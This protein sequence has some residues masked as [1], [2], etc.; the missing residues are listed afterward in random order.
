MNPTAGE[1]D[2]IVLWHGTSESVEKIRAEGLRPER[3]E[4]VFLTD[5]PDLA[6]DYAVTDQARTGSDRIT[7]VEVR[8]SD[9]D[10]SRLLG[11]IDHTLAEDWRDSLAETD[12]CMYQGAIPPGIIIVKDYSDAAAPDL[13]TEAVPAPMV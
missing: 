13:M 12:Q 8:A 9:L 7:I 2:D 5:N 4:A 11:D 3:H 6:I 1:A 10:Q